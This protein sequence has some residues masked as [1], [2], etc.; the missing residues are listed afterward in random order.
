MTPLNQAALD[1]EQVVKTHW[2][3]VK[4]VKDKNKTTGIKGKGYITKN[5]MPIPTGIEKKEKRKERKRYKILTYGIIKKIS[6]SV[7]PSFAKLAVKKKM[8]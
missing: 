3:Q 6:K 4:N 5:A 8:S 7:S 1:Q 2:G